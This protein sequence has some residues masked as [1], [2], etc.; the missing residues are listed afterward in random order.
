MLTDGISVSTLYVFMMKGR[1]RFRWRHSVFDSISLLAFFDL[2]KDASFPILVFRKYK[3]NKPRR[4]TGEQRY[5]AWM[6]GMQDSPL[7]FLVPRSGETQY[8]S[9]LSASDFKAGDMLVMMGCPKVLTKR[10]IKEHA[11]RL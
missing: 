6:G 5:V 9:G 7:Q 3:R 8:L 1:L 10:A 11:G 4:W 2:D